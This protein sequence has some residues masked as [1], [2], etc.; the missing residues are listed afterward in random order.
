M[1][2]SAAATAEPSTDSMFST[3]FG[4]AT[5]RIVTARRHWLQPSKRTLTGHALWRGASTLG[6]RF[7]IRQLL[8]GDDESA[9]YPRVRCRSI[10]AVITNDIVEWQACRRKRPA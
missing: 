10:L 5:F 2:M 3:E 1:A 9:E 8:A 4:L 6:E 7:Q